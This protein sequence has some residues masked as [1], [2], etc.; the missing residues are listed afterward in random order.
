MISIELTGINDVQDAC[1]SAALQ[2]VAKS[3]SAVATI[4]NAI[5]EQAKQN[6]KGELADS[7]TVKMDSD[8]MGATISANDPSAIAT[9]YGADKNAGP[10]LNQAFEANRQSFINALKPDE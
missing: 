1:K 3:Q 2:M 6:A 10:F 8:G 5:A 9:E 4:A 7:I